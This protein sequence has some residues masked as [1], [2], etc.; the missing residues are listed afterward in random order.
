VVDPAGLARE[1]AAGFAACAMISLAAFGPGN[2]VVGALSHPVLRFFG[3]I[4]YSLYLWHAITLTV[5]WHSPRPFTVL[6][7]SG[8]PQPALALLSSLLALMVA[9][10]LAWL[11]YRFVERPGVALGKALLAKTIRRK[12]SQPEALAAPADQG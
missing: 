8:V 1:V 2:A 4:S 10:P 3:R 9:T 5:L 12:G 11:S 7:A 6:I